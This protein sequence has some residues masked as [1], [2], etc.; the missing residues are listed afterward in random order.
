MNEAYTSNQTLYNKMDRQMKTVKEALK[1]KI[2]KE[3]I[4]T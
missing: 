1:K 3:R 2:C 4:A